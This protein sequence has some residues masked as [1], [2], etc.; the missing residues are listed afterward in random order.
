ME[1]RFVTLEG[2]DR[3]VIADVETS[4]RPKSDDD[5][6]DIEIV[7]DGGIEEEVTNVVT[8]V[9]T[10]PSEYML[11]E[12]AEPSEQLVD[13][14]NEDSTPCLTCGRIIQNKFLNIHYKIHRKEKPEEPEKDDA[15]DTNNRNEASTPW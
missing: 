6:D 13:K 3:N 5:D 10:P 2:K 11:D 15:A 12:R 1:G 9:I 14:N 8:D 4:L 7:D